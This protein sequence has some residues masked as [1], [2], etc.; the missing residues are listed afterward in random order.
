MSDGYT[1]NQTCDTVEII[2]AAV[3]SANRLTKL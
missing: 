3:F 2:F 1:V